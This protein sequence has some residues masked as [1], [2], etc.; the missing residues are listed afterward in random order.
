MPDAQNGNETNT[1]VEAPN[2]PRGWTRLVSNVERKMH[3]RHS[4]KQEESPTDRAARVTAKATVWLAIFTVVLAGTSIGTVVILKNQLKEMH[5]GGIDTHALADAT[6]KMKGSAE[7]SAQA[8]RDFADTAGDI[9]DSIDT[10][11]DKLDAQAKGIEQSRKSS[12]SASAKALNASI[13]SS[14]LDQRAWIGAADTVFTFSPNDPIKV[15]IGVTNV[16]KSPAV[17]VISRMAAI[18]KHSGSSLQISDISYVPTIKEN[19]NGTMYPGQKFPLKTFSS[20]VVSPLQAA[21]IEKLSSGSDVVYVF[22]EI[23]YKDIFSRQHWT[24][25]CII[26]NK[27]LKSGAPCALYNDSDPDEQKE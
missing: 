1:P 10:A 5:D 4:K 27:D 21:F 9:K 26:V 12:Q 2:E 17:D 8:S 13:N 25:F 19:S 7:K 16:G 22:G 6:E 24:H 11:V 3:E 15:E 23:R 18:T 14:R 20:D